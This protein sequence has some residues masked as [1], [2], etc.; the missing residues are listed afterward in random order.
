MRKTEPDRTP[1]KNI[2]RRT[3]PICG[4]GIVNFELH[5]RPA[6]NDD[7]GHQALRQ[8][9]EQLF[10]EALRGFNHRLSTDALT[11]LRQRAWCEAIRRVEGGAEE[12]P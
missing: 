10:A 12:N 11:M 4:R 2:R 3:C 7:P 9:H 6:V 5:T 8:F 1:F